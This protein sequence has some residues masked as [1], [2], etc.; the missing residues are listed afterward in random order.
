MAGRSDIKVL[1]HG[2]GDAGPMDGLGTLP[3]DRR[4]H[5]KQR[6]S[7]EPTVVL[8]EHEASISF[9]DNELTDV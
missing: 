6:N 8:G 2:T 7:G 9:L 4:T 3:L 1:G 5:A